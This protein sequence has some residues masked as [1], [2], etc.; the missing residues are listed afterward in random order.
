MATRTKYNDQVWRNLKKR[1]GRG[2]PHVKVGVL[3]ARGGA[4]QHESGISLIELAA[5]HEFGS[6]AAKIPE[7]SFIRRTFNKNR[8]L[9]KLTVHLARRIINERLTIRRALEQLGTWGAAEVKKTIASGAPIPPPLKPGT[10][11]QKGSS[12][13]LVDTGRLLNSIAHE[14]KA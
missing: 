6:P 1:L 9:K 11:R 10:I 7:R 12:R 8:E 2:S 4:Q 14:V 5:I 13:P 3:A